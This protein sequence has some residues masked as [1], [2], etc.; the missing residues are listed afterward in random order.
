MK[1]KPE[2]RKVPGLRGCEVQSLFLKQVSC[3]EGG[4]KNGCAM[5]KIIFSRT[6][7]LL[8]SVIL[9]TSISAALAVPVSGKVVRS[10]GK[11]YIV[12]EKLVSGKRITYLIKG[13]TY[14]LSKKAGYSVTVLG[15]VRDTGSSNRKELRIKKVLRSTNDSLLEGMG[16]GNKKPRRKGSLVDEM[17]KG[18]K[19]LID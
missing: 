10:S 6:T 5:K 17:T 9:F 11:T 14:G 19:S 1:N 8:L 7:A 3:R 15:E 16:K 12:E 13:N 4:G 2:K 18:R